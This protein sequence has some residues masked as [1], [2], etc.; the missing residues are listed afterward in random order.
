[1]ANPKKKHSPAR[2]DSRRS[3]NFRLV[4]GSM[5]RCSNCGA[6]RPPHRVCAACGYYGKELVVAPKTKKSK[7]EE[8]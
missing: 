1:M 2:R 8:K 4:M 5:S 6:A 3:A 7:G